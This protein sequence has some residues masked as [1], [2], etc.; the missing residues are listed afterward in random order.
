MDFPPPEEV[1][2]VWPNKLDEVTVVALMVNLGI[3]LFSP[4]GLG[5]LMLILLSYAS[6]GIT[7]ALKLLSNPVPTPADE[8][9]LVLAILLLL[10]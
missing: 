8:D 1:F 9:Y 5:M 7:Q 4:G 6:S 3:I 10:T 2:K